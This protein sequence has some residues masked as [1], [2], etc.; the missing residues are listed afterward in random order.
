MLQASGLLQS[1]GGARIG[2][3]SRVGPQ[4]SVHRTGE[5]FEV[6]WQPEQ[7]AAPALPESCVF[8]ASSPDSSACILVPTGDTSARC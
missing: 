1:T 7:P 5:G 4:V 8:G 2:A 3:V 6:A